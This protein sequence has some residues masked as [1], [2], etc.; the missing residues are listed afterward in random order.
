[1]SRLAPLIAVVG[2]DGSG[3]STLVADLLA[4]LAPG[5]RVAS[6]YLGLGSGAMGERIRRWPLIGPALERRLA[7][8]G[9][10]ARDTRARIPG[11]GTAIVIYALSLSRRRRFDRIMRLRAEG[12]TVFTDRYP[13]IEVPGFYDGP[14][15]SAAA[16]GSAAVA[17]LAARER[18]LYEDMTRHRPTLVIRLAI[19][20]VTAH[21]RKP[22]HDLTL[23]E[24]KVA[25]TPCL[26]FGGA[27]LV[28]LDAAQPYAAVRQAALQAVRQAIG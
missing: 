21:A 10:Q 25:V 12:V 14:G 15:L 11:L 9:R 3:K 23:I 19:D 5:R 20:A 17:R 7:R 22:D 4:T 13:Q 6:A 27:P 24:R 28:D 2:C 16:A 18:R 8:K 1:M 26:T